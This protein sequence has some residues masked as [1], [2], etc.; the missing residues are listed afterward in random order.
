L[1]LI[2][3]SIMK[4]RC[5]PG[6]GNDQDDAIGHLTRAIELNPN[7]KD[8]YFYRG[9]AH[10]SK[11]EFPEAQADFLQVIELESA[12]GNTFSEDARQKI[13]EL[14]AL[15]AKKEHLQNLKAKQHEPLASSAKYIERGQ[16]YLK[17]GE[18]EKAYLDFDEAIR[19]EPTNAKAFRFRGASL[20]KIGEAELAIKDYSQA[21]KLDPN[22]SDLHLNRG[23]LQQILAIPMTLLVDLNEAIRLNP[24]NAMA[25]HMRA[26]VHAEAWYDGDRIDQATED[27]RKPSSSILIIQRSISPGLSFGVNPVSVARKRMPL[28]ILIRPSA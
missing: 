20:Y 9:I 5:I 13:D 4:I 3:L 11:D 24:S 28:P 22:N 8:A 26:K 7:A 10:K 6:K 17:T 18:W 25:Y 27:L 1:D 16:T 23:I 21:I 19:L 15:E 14:K 2:M 12:P